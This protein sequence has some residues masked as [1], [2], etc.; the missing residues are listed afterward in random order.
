[1]SAWNGLSENAD[2]RSWVSLPANVQVL[3]VALPAGSH[4]LTLKQSS[5][6]A[7]IEVPV[8]V[9]AGSKTIVHVVRAGNG[10]DLYT[11]VISLNA[12]KSAEKTAR[13]EKVQ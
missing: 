7:A 4:Q 6:A 12:G 2:L 10:K 9:A 13:A 8:Q 1:M 11:S 5:L 3:R